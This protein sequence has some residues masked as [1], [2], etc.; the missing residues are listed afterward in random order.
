[1]LAI[2]TYLHINFVAVNW[3]HFLWLMWSNV[4]SSRYDW[5]IFSSS[6]SRL[7]DIIRKINISVISKLN[8]LINLNAALNKGKIKC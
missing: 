8:G 4:Y 5:F 2:T 7:N 1:M 3:E 6:L